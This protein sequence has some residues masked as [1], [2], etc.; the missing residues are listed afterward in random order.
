[1]AELNFY[2]PPPSF[3]SEKNKE[4]DDQDNEERMCVENHAARDGVYDMSLSDD[5]RITQM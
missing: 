3:S 1:M 5:D 4:T 2:L